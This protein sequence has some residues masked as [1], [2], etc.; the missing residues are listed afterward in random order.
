MRGLFDTDGYVTSYVGFSCY[1]KY[2]ANDIQVM[3]TEM[4]I[5]TN[6]KM[7]KNGVGKEG[8][9]KFIYVLHLKGIFA[10]KKFSQRIGFSIGYKQQLLHDR[11]QRKYCRSRGIKVPYVTKRLIDWSKEK[12]ITTY[13]NLSLGYS[14]KNFEKFS[15]GINALASFVQ[16]AE[17]FGY[18]VPDDIKQLVSNPLFEVCSVI[19]GDVVETIDIALDHDAHDFIAYGLITHNTNPCYIYCL[20]SNTLGDNLTVVAHA[21]GH[22]DFFKNNIHF[23][24]TNTDMLNVMA[25]HGSRIRKYMSRWGS[26]KVTTFIDHVM[27]IETMVDGAKAWRQ[28]TI[29]EKHL[30]DKRKYR[31][32]KR[33]HVDSDRLYMDPYIN[34]KDFKEK[35]NIKNNKRYA[36]DELGIFT[37]STRD[38]FG[39][40][41]ENAPLKPWQQD[42]MSMLYEEALYF[43][44]QRQTKTLNEGWASTVDHVIMAEQGFIGLGQKSHD[45]GIFEYAIHK[46][47]VLGGRYSTNPYKLGYTLLADIRERYDKGRF[48]TEYEECQD[49]HKKENWDTNTQ[50][51]KEKIFEVRNHYDDFT[52][53]NEFFT[54]EFCRKHE[55]FEWKKQP[56]GEFVIASRDFK[57]IKDKLL[58]RHINGS[59][60]D[61][62]LEETN[63]KGRGYLFLQHYSTG[64]RLYDPY[65]REVLTSVRSIWGNDVY[66]ATKNP[67]GTEYIYECHG[68]DSSK[69]I[70]LKTKEGFIGADEDERE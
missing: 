21:T 64:Q 15:V 19:D 69:D 23:S 63:F 61:I 56:N 47:G 50:L 29:R 65:V 6:L 20:N 11:C 3:L 41:K 42:I 38:I 58:R 57:N 54:E 70:K 48:G 28:K 52:L 53:I 26:E 44:P 33:L 16:R 22:N 51:G 2:F 25:N 24:A 17:G 13:I 67:D 62:R 35:E 59:L 31:N 55:Y 14:V 9:Q 39:F 40:L 37:K 7:L 49:M 32:P 36:A 34:T 66:L 68:V 1:N 10:D 45:C 27:R 46:M 60:P 43:F 30:R 18:E 4:G 8:D 5:Q 12:K